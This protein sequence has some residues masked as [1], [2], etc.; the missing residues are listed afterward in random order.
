MTDLG[1]TGGVIQAANAQGRAGLV[2]FLP[3]GHPSV[4][5]TIVAAKEVARTADILLIGHPSTDPS[6]VGA[7]VERASVRACAQGIGSD[8]LWPVIE[9]L[10]PSKP[11][12]VLAQ[13]RDILRH[14]P[15]GFAR[16]LSHAGCVGVLTPDVD[17]EHA[18]Q[19]VAATDRFGLDRIFAA[20]S[21][22]TADEVE[23]LIARSRGWIYVPTIGDRLDHAQ[24]VATLARLR[25]AAP[26]MPLGLD[27]T[28]E[29]ASDVAAVADLA[30][31]VVAGTVLMAAMPTAPGQPLDRLSAVMAEVGAGLAR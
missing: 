9:E 20:K 2:G 17:A 23:A 1:V 5:T 10:A 26:G 25:E 31:V 19:W 13:W 3:L 7:H 4:A 30:D 16:E 21:T 27:I 14:G 22:D 24:G 8:E 11:V 29:T 12:L 18:A 6:C 15:A 28:G